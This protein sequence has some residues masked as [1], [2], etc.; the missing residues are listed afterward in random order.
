MASR[1]F[2]YGI[3]RGNIVEKSQRLRMMDAETVETAGR[4]A[5]KNG[6]RTSS[7]EVLIY[8]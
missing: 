1:G 3:A 7:S 5:G 4:N 2:W 6:S 8:H